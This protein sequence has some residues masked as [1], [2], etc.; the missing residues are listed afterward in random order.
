MKLRR[1]DSLPVKRNITGNEYFVGIDAT[2]ILMHIADVKNYFG[3][4]S[5]TSMLGI[6][7]PTSMPVAGDG[8]YIAL[9]AGTYVNFGG[10][11]VKESSLAVIFAKGGVFTI[12]QTN[13]GGGYL[14]DSDINAP[15]GVTGFEPIGK[16][17]AGDKRAVS[18]EEVFDKAM[19]IGRAHV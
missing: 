4:S 10:V 17:E 14:T 13:I 9:E 8:F 7:T 19:K 3:V 2:D 11:V 15:G 18:G 6:A 1:L 5:T 16:V 12:T